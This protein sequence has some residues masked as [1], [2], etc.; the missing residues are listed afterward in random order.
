MKD[1]GILYGQLI[2]LRYLVYLRSSE[3]FYGDLVYFELILHVF[4]HFGIFYQEKSGNLAT[5]GCRFCLVHT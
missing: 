4:R 3:I 5:Q 1:V 2:Y